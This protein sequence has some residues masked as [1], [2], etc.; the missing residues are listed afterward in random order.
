M[1]SARKTAARASHSIQSRPKQSEDNFRCGA[2]YTSAVKSRTVIL[3]LRVRY[4]LSRRG[5]PEQF[6]E[7][8]VTAGYKAEGGNLTWHTANAPDLLSLLESAEVSGNIT[9]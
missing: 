6:A 4:I 7:E 1:L 3:M 8:V 9:K 5:Q 2:D